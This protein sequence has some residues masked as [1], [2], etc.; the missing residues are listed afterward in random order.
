MIG[1]GIWLSIAGRK[2]DTCR[3][4]LVGIMIEERLGRGF[5]IGPQIGVIKNEL[6]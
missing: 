5:I 3:Y 1:C 6:G 2:R 4:L